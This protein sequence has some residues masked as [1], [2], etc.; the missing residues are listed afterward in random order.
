MHRISEQPVLSEW[1]KAAVSVILT[2]ETDEILWKHYMTRNGFRRGLGRYSLHIPNP[3]PQQIPQRK[4][5][6]RGRTTSEGEVGVARIGRCQHREVTCNWRREQH[7]L[8]VG[9]Y[10]AHWT[11]IVEN[12]PACP[13][14]KKSRDV[15]AIRTTIAWNSIVAVNNPFNL[16]DRQWIALISFNLSNHNAPVNSIEGDT[17]LDLPCPNVKDRHPSSS[18]FYQRYLAIQ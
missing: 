18:P 7:Y 15:K 1:P 2:M 8:R 5:V 17:W 3:F 9:V 11:M 6:D 4:H 12:R 10:T 13:A 14:T 16:G